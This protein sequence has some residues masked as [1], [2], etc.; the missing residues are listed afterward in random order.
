MKRVNLCFLLGLLGSL[1]GNFGAWAQ[2]ACTIYVKAPVCAGSDYKPALVGQFSG[3]NSNLE[4]TYVSSGSYMGYY[5]Y[6]FSENVQGQEFKVREL[7]DQKWENE[8]LGY[9]SGSMQVR[10]NW[11]RMN[12]L[13]VTGSLT[14]LD[15]SNPAEYCWQQCIPEAQPDYKTQ[16]DMPVLYIRTK[17]NVPVVSKDVYV[18]GYYYLDN[19]GIEGIKSIASEELPDTLQIKGRGNYTW[20]GFEKKPYRLKL[21]NKTALLGLKKNKHFGLL[22]HADDRFGWMRNTMGFLLSK[23]MGLKWTPEQQPVEVVLNGDYIGLYMLTELIRVDKDRVNI[24]EQPDECTHPDSITGGWLVEIDNYKEEGNVELTEPEYPP[25]HGSRTAMFTPKTPE[26]LSAQQRSYLTNALQTMQN[27]IYTNDDQA[28]ADVM[29]IESL[30][31]FY[32]VQEIMS[33]CE[34]FNGSCYLHKDMGEHEKWFWGPVW[35]F[36][37][38]Y[39]RNNEQMIYEGEVMFAQKW[40]A[41]M[42]AHPV[43]QKA[44]QK[45]WD[46]WR[47]YEAANVAAVINEMAERISHAAVRDAKR[48]PQYNHS[49]MS[50]GAKDILD[51]Y[52]WRVDMLS[53]L[54]GN[55]KED[56]PTEAVVN[57]ME[58]TAATKVIRNGQLYIIRGGME[59]TVLGQ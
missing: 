30:A 37:N 36:G 10:D 2:G 43:L 9:G 32:L 22:A 27:I 40:I 12:N 38:S 34:S 48:W 28:M 13:S 21:N 6:T 11:Y 3:W 45:E 50:K 16:T 23:Q 4:M 19:R 26:V 24:V 46:H 58:R 7:N 44:V 56:E 17:D 57:S 33:N 15:F 41:R 55:G 59:Y 35:D 39:D 5:S 8:V 14:V 54:W 25:Y 52:D 20:S 53:R 42:L 51:R 1:T 29:D 49:N 47:Y 31:K 18:K